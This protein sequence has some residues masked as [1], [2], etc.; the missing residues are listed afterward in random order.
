MIDP[1]DGSKTLTTISPRPTARLFPLAPERVGRFFC[2]CYSGN[3]G[4]LINRRGAFD[5]LGRLRVMFDAI[6]LQCLLTGDCDVSRGESVSCAADRGKILKAGKLSY[7][8]RV[9]VHQR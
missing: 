3:T 9:E 4:G 8:S 2:A 5:S 1:V 7:G 6:G